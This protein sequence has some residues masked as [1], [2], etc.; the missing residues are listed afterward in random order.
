MIEIQNKHTNTIQTVVQ[1]GEHGLL[2]AT[3]RN[4]WLIFHIV[5]GTCALWQII[6]A[7]DSQQATCVP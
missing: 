3:Y 2:L 4:L 7:C 1:R 5:K 6:L